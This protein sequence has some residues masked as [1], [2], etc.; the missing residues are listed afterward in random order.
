MP[1]RRVIAAVSAAV[2]FVSG[3][4]T[5]LA[6][7]PTTTT[8]TTTTTTAPTT[9]VTTTTDPFTSTSTA[10]TTTTATST[11][12]RTP[13][14]AT[15]P[16]TTSVPLHNRAT[17]A[18]EQERGALKAIAPLGG[19]RSHK[20]PRRKISKPLKITPPLGQRDF[21]FPVVGISDYVDTYGAFRADVPGNWHHGDDIIAPLGAPV[22]AVADGTIN[23]VGYE[24]VGGWRL[25]VR[26][27][28]SDEFYYAHLS[29]YAPSD[30][31]SNR[32]R[33]GQVIGFV[34]YTGDAFGGASHV[35][36]EIHPRQLLRLGYDGAVDPTTYLD[37]WN[38]LQ[39][40]DAPRPVHPRLPRQPLF[41][42]QA[43]YVFR[44]LLAARHVRAQQPMPLASPGI[45]ALARNARSA[46]DE[47]LETHGAAPAANLRARGSPLA[48]SLLA[49]LGALSVFAMTTLLVR[50]G[51]RLR[52]VGADRVVEAE[53]TS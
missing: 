14:T 2:L 9:T 48:V 24:K 49:G 23:R 33:A 5:A 19:V 32:V 18:H 4:A 13:T 52:G 43:S 35:H 50:L 21:T 39:S 20:K 7:S 37:S 12:A 11:T 27:S 6:D 51:R 30:F 47:Q 8:D 46:S 45:A 53:H 25:W 44:E 1:L 40:V 3:V 22:V 31:H 29:G 41:R 26:D 16:A 10:P 34:G 28:A 38:H 42:Q 17:G 36:F 15:T